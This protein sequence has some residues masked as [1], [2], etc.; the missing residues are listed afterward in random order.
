[1][2][3]G[4]ALP[5]LVISGLSIIQDFPLLI[6][7]GQSRIELDPEI[8]IIRGGKRFVLDYF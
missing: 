1:M 6:T 3:Q 8:K 2:N 4:E 5:S 7:R